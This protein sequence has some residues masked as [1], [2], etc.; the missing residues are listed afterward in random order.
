MTDDV[1]KMEFSQEMVD[2]IDNLVNKAIECNKKTEFSANLHLEID[3]LSVP[4]RVDDKQVFA[5][6][7][8]LLPNI[9]NYLVN[10]LPQFVYPYLVASLQNLS[11]MREDPVTI[12]ELYFYFKENGYFF[13]SP[14]TE[15]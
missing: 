2:Y 14:D 15:G 4:V 1:I 5:I 13:N 10:I 6:G 3:E 11:D 12:N 7:S 9:M 8:L